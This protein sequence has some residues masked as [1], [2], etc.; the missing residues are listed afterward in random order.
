MAELELA[1][2]VIAAIVPVYGFLYKLRE[3][4]RR[5]RSDW[6]RCTRCLAAAAGK[7]PECEKCVAWA[8]QGGDV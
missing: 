6:L 8:G 7:L 2:V 1:L 5:F 3:D 4:L